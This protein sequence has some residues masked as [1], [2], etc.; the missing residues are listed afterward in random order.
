MVF[1]SVLSNIDEIPSINTSANMFVSRDFNAWH[2]DW[3]I[4]SGGTDRPGK[5]CYNFYISNYLT[6]MVNFPTHN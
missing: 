2:K 4:Y 5:I 1:D 6:Q 3:L